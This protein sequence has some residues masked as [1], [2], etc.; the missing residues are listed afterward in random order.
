MARTPDMAR[1]EEIARS[2][3]EAMLAQG[4]QNT[5]MSA[6]AKALGM[7]RPTLYWYFKDLGAVFDAILEILLKEQVDFVTRRLSGIA[8][9]IDL[10]FAYAQGVDAFYAEREEV[11]AFLLQLWAAAGG[12]SPDRTISTTREFFEPRRVQAIEMVE[13]GIELG[14]VAPC[15]PEVLV[16]SVGAFI[17]GL[18]VQ[19]VTRQ[20]DIKPMHSFLWEHVLQPLKRSPR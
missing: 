14:L 5:S 8:H 4:V 2:A 1:R 18:L 12:E 17:D 20:N 16:G 3:F 11:I 13:A 6:L 10:L 19:R 7:K 15:D 9:P